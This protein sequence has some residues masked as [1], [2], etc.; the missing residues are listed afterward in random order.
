[1]LTIHP[2]DEA[3]WHFVGLFEISEER[4]R[5]WVDYDRFAALKSDV[6]PGGIAP[7]DLVTTAPLDLGELLPQIRYTPPSAQPPEI[8]VEAPY[9]PPA[10]IVQGMAADIDG[11]APVLDLQAVFAG[12]PPAPGHPPVPQ[13]PHVTTEVHE[14]PEW[15]LPPPDSVS[16][17]VVQ[18]SRLD[19]DDSVNADR[20]ASGVVSADALLARLGG[21]T[22]Q[23]AQ[24]GVVLN[25][26]HP[27]NEASF[28]P[29]AK[30]FQASAAQ[31][32]QVDGGDSVTLQGS[33]VT[34]HYLNGIAVGE[35][36]DINDH[37]PVSRQDADVAE[38]SA[39][40]GDPNAAESATGAT[41]SSGVADDEDGPDHDLVHGDN[42][43]IN[44]ASITAAWIAAPVVVAA[45]DAYSYTIISQTNVWSDVD[46]V[47]GATVGAATGSG[48]P[49][50]SLN[51]SSYA[52]FSNPMP[53]RGGNGDAPQYWATATLE[54]SLISCNWIDQYNLVSDND[55]TAITIMG[56][57]T[58]YLMGENGAVNKVSLA[59][60]GTSY[61]VI[62]IDGHVINLN[63]VLQTNVLLDDD[64]IMVSGGTATV[65][66]DDNLLANE[67]T[68]I[69]TGETNIR[70]TTADQ[71]AMLAN[72]VNGDLVLSQSVLNDPM[73]RDLEVVRVLHIKGDMVS[74]NLVR[75]TNVL[76]DSDQIEVY[77]DQLNR[78]PGEVSVLTGSNML[79]NSA[80]IT[81]FGVDS[82]VYAGGHV[83]SDALLHQAELVSTD[84]PLM[85]Q[86]G[87]GL[88]SEAVL[89]LADGMLGDDLDAFEFRP[90]GA[91][92]TPSADA[93]ET[94][95]S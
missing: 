1:M 92:G 73:L 42:T 52:S 56:E 58:L 67:S 5:M 81:E 28:L 16:V 72:A 51:Y 57:K 24:L 82:T 63:A 27:E 18:W 8:T 64:R 11:G 14:P 40:T 70:H 2:V 71:D 4:G 61:D 25:L 83:Y 88:A 41:A 69:R 10:A 33:A 60:L 26:D 62:V 79:I 3:I 45:G 35:R 93:M 85:P 75:Q 44:Q 76:G 21:L 37:L 65:S 23:A 7:L 90:I 19:D 74:L 94:V 78:G 36:P 34:G 95:L 15:V 12:I 29:I 87:N 20:M 46:S 53:A 49:T 91:D 39:T 89:F 38:D 31:N 9:F 68:I 43:L 32:P 54:G 50:E 66:S 84:A 30:T 22:A 17:I 48:N 59:E 55:V 86:G 77:L 80:I 6:D 13:T 47:I